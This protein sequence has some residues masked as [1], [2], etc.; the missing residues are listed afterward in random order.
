MTTDGRVHKNLYTFIV[1]SVWQCDFYSF[2]LVSY[3]YIFI[4]SICLLS[5]TQTFFSFTPSLQRVKLVLVPALYFPFQHSSNCFSILVLIPA[6]YY[7]FQH[8]IIYYS[9]HPNILL[10]ITVPYF[11][12]QTLNIKCSFLIFIPSLQY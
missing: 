1:S 11:S 4:L 6:A 2:Q 5:L 12:F 3:Q 9:G 8:L 10:F 7:S